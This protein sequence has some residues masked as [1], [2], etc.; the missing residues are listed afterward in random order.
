MREDMLKD[1][2]QLKDTNPKDAIGIK[3]VPFSTVS[4]AVM[5]ELAIAMA[6]GAI[7]YG[8]HNY[9]VAGIRA[10]V[11]YDA[12]LRHLTK[13]WEG[14]DNDPDSGLCH[15]I[16]AFASLMVLRDA[17]I[18]KN[19]TDDRPPKIPEGFI[20]GLNDA[21]ME[22]IKKYPTSLPAFTEENKND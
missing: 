13:W 7:K 19:W 4:G 6:E 20:E 2:N 15:V 16:K 3:K 18:V 22:I 12:A 10:S 14:E 9:R 11:Y 5:A 17:M 1:T 21:M 8:R